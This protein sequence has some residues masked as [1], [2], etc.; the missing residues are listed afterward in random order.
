MECVLCEIPC[1]CFSFADRRCQIYHLPSISFFLC[2]LLLLCHTCFPPNHIWPS[3]PPS[4][5]PSRQ[6][7]LHLHPQTQVLLS[8]L[9]SSTSSSTTSSS[10]PLLLF[11]A[12]SSFSSSGQCPPDSQAGS[13]AVRQ[14]GFWKSVFSSPEPFGPPYPEWIPACCYLSRQQHTQERDQLERG[15]RGGRK[16]RRR[17][18]AMTC[19]SLLLLLFPACTCCVTCVWMCSTRRARPRLA[20][21]TGV[22]GGGGGGGSVPVGWFFRSIILPRRWLCTRRC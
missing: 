1:A 21:T 7:R 3:R 18:K 14:A 8:I 22:G 2:L 11:S 12:P 15:E 5:Y 17:G 20:G 16:G 10:S 13:Q 6:P 19:L 9:A 4:T